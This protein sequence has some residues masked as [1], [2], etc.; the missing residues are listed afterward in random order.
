MMNTAVGD[1]QSIID[2]CER[3]SVPQMVKVTVGDVMIHKVAVT[4]GI[5]LVDIQDELDRRAP[6][7]TRAKGTIE[8][9]QT[10]SFIALVSHYA[11]DSTIVYVDAV[12][13]PCIV[14]VINDNLTGNRAGWR[15]HMVRYVPEISEEWKAWGAKQEESLS[16][17]DFAELLEDR[18]LNVVSLSSVGPKTSQI[19]ERLG[20]KV[21]SP[22]DIQ[23]I[24][25]GLSIKVDNHVQEVRRLDSGES[26]VVFSEKHN[27]QDGK[28][29]SVPNALVIAIPVFKGGPAY[30]LVVRL[31]YRLREGRISL[32]YSI[33][34]ADKAKQDA[35]HDMT[36]TLRTG[37]PHV[38]F[39]E[40]VP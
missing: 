5:Q 18:C 21:G 27:G 11:T 36:V 1:A 28:P 35:V 7:P 4:K 40:G 15:D 33:V 13:H 10:D 34:H 37:L 16:Q 29:L 26:Q 22:A 6:E 30:T 8:V 32:S 3:L 9:H 20:V 31:R 38:L 17:T 12:E 2:L 25:K 19:I 24:A 23:G 39:V 14:A